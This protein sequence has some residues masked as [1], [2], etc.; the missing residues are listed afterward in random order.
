MVVL[1][2][3]DQQLFTIAVQ[4]DFQQTMMVLQLQRDIVE[5]DRNGD[6]LLLVSVDNC[7]YQ[8]LFA[9]LARRGGT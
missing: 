9:K 3:F 5:T 6:G 2:V 8:S 4:L 1:N 7:R